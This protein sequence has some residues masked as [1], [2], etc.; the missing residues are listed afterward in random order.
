MQPKSHEPFD[1][2]LDYLRERKSND[3]S[4]SDVVA[5]AEIAAHSMQEFIK[6][7][8]H[9]VHRELRE[10]AEYI[11]NMKQEIGAFQA[12][13]LKNSRIPAAGQELGAVVQSTEE[14]TNTIMECAEEIL[15]ADTSDIDAYQNFVNDRVMRIFEACSFQDL[16]GQR[17]GKVVETLQTIEK[18]VTRFVDAV[19]AKDL[20]S[21]TDAAEEARERRKQALLLNGPQL[22]GFGNDQSSVDKLF[23]D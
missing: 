3:P 17:V 20:S 22:E 13:D 8:D 4:F 14:A 23:K 18:R 2:I 5:L 21:I 19:N 10:I 15:A 1:S 12:N 16:T 6:S 11:T 7:M 9:A